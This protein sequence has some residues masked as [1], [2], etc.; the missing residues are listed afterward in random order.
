VTELIGGSQTEVIY[1]FLPRDA[2]RTRGLCGRR[3]I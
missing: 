1:Q 3:V 2:M